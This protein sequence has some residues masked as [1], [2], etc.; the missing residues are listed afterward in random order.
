VTTPFSPPN[1]CHSHQGYLLYQRILAS[2]PNRMRARTIG[3]LILVQHLNRQRHQI[4]KNIDALPRVPSPHN[5]RRP[6]VTVLVYRVYNTRSPEY[7][8]LQASTP[9]PGKHLVDDYNESA[10]SPT[11]VKLLDSRN[12]HIPAQARLTLVCRAVRIGHP[13]LCLKSFTMTI[14]DYQSVLYPKRCPP[15]PRPIM[16]LSIGIEDV[17]ITSLKFSDQPLCT[18]HLSAIMTQD[19]IPAWTGQDPWALS[20][21]F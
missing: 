11:S 20:I 15:R 18:S 9:H 8:L 1:D 17:V 6:Q 2:A 19:L 10:Q 14:Q 13:R 4:F 12:M 7:L 16:C 3:K 5:I 21:T